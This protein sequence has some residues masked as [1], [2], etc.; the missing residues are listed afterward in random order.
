MVPLAF[1]FIHLLQ[2]THVG[3]TFLIQNSLTCGDRLCCEWCDS[4]RIDVDVIIV[5]R[6]RIKSMRMM[7]LRFDAALCPL[8]YYHQRHPVNY[9]LL[10]IFTLSLAFAVGLTCAFT[11]GEY[12]S[13]SGLLMF[14]SLA[15]WCDPDALSATR[16]MV[17]IYWKMNEE[18]VSMGFQ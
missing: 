18:T 15:F 8:Y 3:F 9:L 2:F 4:T 14:A 7:V 5:H 13:W 1:H 12:E 10:G 16:E 11:S 6:F 17:D